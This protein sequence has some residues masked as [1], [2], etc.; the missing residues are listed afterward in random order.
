MRERDILGIDWKYGDVVLDNPKTSGIYCVLDNRYEYML[1]D[2]QMRN[3]TPYVEIGVAYTSGLTDAEYI[4]RQENGLR[5]LLEEHLGEK[6]TETR[7]EFKTVPE[8]AEVV[9]TYGNATTRA[10][11]VHTNGDDLHAERYY[12]ITEKK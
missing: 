8:G 9:E 11:L 4:K 6:N 10:A 12:I 3:N 1:T 7:S 2:T 5:W